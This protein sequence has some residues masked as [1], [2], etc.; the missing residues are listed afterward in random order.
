MEVILYTKPGCP[1]CQKAREHYNSRNIAFED[2]NAQDNLQYRK[3][4]FAYNDN[5]PTVPTIIEDGN[6]KSV[7]WEGRG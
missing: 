5:N 1:Y 7:G 4:M 3:E 2:R 6:L